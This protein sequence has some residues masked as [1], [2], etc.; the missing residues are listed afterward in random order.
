VES[1]HQASTYVRIIEQRQGRK[2]AC[3]EEIAW[4]QSWIDSE[5]LSESVLKYGDSEYANYLSNIPMQ[6]TEHE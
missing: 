5:Q 6:E 2:I 3:L 4:M 1:L